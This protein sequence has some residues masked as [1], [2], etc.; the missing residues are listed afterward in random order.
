MER[1]LLGDYD[2]VK[3]DELISYLSLVED[4]IF[5]ESGKGYIKILDLFASKKITLDQL[6]KQHKITYSHLFLVIRAKVILRIKFAF[7]VFFWRSILLI[8]QD[9]QHFPHPTPSYRLERL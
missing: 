2:K 6:F 7:F 4:E 8:L 9:R 3:N 5:W 1:K